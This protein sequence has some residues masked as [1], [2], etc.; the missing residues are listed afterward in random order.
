MVYFASIFRAFSTKEKLW[1]GTLGKM[2]L[3]VEPGRDL[4]YNEKILANEAISHAHHRYSYPYL[5]Q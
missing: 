1:R 2:G 3:G 5:S 4:W